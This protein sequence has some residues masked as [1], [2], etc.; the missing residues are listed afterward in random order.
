MT[1][2]L[3]CCF[4]FCLS[5]CFS[6]S[7]PAGCHRACL[8][9]YFSDSLS[10]LSASLI[11]CLY[12]S[13][14]PFLS[15]YLYLSLCLF[16]SLHRSISASFHFCFSVSPPLCFS[17]SLPAIPPPSFPASLHLCLFPSLLLYL[18]ASLSL[19]VT[20]LVF[21]IFSVHL[22]LSHCLSPCN[23]PSLSFLAYS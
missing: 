20:L 9:L 22:C 1:N 15:S 3:Y 11:L 6:A 8:P 17:D 4:D 14:P 10:P 13:L 19:P 18:S 16:P 21:F 2:G 5:F 12:A 7:L 23:R